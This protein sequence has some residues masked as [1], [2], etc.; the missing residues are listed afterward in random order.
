MSRLVDME[1]TVR[2][3]VVTDEEVALQ[4]GTCLASAT[5]R[6]LRDF[7]AE[8]TP[9]VVIDSVNECRVTTC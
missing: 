4:H 9:G 6:A 7:A 1:I 2:L 5:G 3:R 8:R